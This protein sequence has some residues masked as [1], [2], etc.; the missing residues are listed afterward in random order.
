MSELFHKFQKSQEDVYEAYMALT[1]KVNGGTIDQAKAFYDALQ[2]MVSGNFYNSDDARVAKMMMDSIKNNKAAKAVLPDDIDTYL[3]DRLDITMNALEAV[4]F[5][6]SVL[7]EFENKVKEIEQSYRGFLDIG[8]E[9]KLTGLFRDEVQRDVSHLYVLAQKAILQGAEGKDSLE[10]LRGLDRVEIL[11]D[12]ADLTRDNV[13]H[14]H[15]WI[16]DYIAD[17]MYEREDSAPE[18]GYD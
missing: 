16:Y 5:S 9:Q 1:D 6:D 12:N 11:L 7:D 17:T 3:R 8:S 15:K 4:S 13:S 10:L 18:L 14:N 2:N